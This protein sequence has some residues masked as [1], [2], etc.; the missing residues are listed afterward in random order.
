MKRINEAIAVITVCG[1]TC[2]VALIDGSKDGA[3][4]SMLGVITG[5]LGF[6]IDFYSS[7]K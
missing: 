3:Y 2:M 4:Y 5:F 1:I 7:K 6:A